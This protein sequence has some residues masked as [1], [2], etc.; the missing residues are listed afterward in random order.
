MWAQELQTNLSQVQNLTDAMHQIR[1]MVC[2]DDRTKEIL[3]LGSWNLTRNLTTEICKLDN[4]QFQELVEDVVQDLEWNKMYAQ[5]AECNGRELKYLNN[6]NLN[7]EKLQKALRAVSGHFEAPIH[8][9]CGGVYH[10]LV[11][12]ELMCLLPCLML[13]PY[14]FLF[15]SHC[16]EGQGWEIL[17]H[18]PSVFPSRFFLHCNS[19][20]HCCIA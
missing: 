5:L 7:A 9:Y 4:T 14:M 1:S 18:C 6:D 15:I 16:V 13:H 2:T 3:W 12:V 20:M 8:K 10:G 11:I 17:K 19:K